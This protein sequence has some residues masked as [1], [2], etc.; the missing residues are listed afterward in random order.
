MKLR[1]D[2]QFQDQVEQFRKETQLKYERER[3]QFEEQKQK[4][5]Y[6]IQDSIDNLSLGTSDKQ[7]LKNEIDDLIQEQ[8]KLKTKIDSL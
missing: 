6:E 5:L 1:I 4:R 3:R 7:K 8:N 2:Q